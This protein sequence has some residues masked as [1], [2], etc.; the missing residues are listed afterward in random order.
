M[1]SGQPRATYLRISALIIARNEVRRIH[2]FIRQPGYAR[3]D[4]VYTGLTL[5]SDGRD[6]GQTVDL[7]LDH[8]SPCLELAIHSADW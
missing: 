8:Y 7:I 4:F 5:T 1:S 3:Q 2:N 6:G